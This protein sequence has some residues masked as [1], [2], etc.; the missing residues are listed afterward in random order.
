[1]ND[2]AT[3]SPGAEKA[4]DTGGTSTTV[5][6]HR[7]AE[8]LQQQILTGVLEPGARIRQEEVARE[9][10][11]SRLP[12]REALRILH[13]QGLVTLKANSGAWVSQLDM[14]EFEL[15][16][17]IRERLEPLALAE[18]I[19]HLSPAAIERLDEI[20]DE[21][22]ANQ[23]IDRFLQLDRELHLLSY[24]G[25]PYQELRDM[26]ER[27]W[28]TT[29]LYRRAYLEQEGHRRDWVINAEHR[30]LIDAIRRADT[31][32][33]EQ[34]LAGHIRRTRIA[35]VPAIKRHHPSPSN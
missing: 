33:A 16:Y 27:L 6:S 29:Q 26:V 21:I 19:P 4:T 32:D 1:M 23:S 18:S 8:H 35:L 20:Q 15:S 9:L 14:D 11:A 10:G 3:P 2:P 7:I 24:T 13:S 28:N 31:T 30:L 12:V 5:A 17:K 22:E 34:V 25:N